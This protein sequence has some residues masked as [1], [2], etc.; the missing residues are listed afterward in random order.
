MLK[1]KIYGAHLKLLH[2]LKRR[3][4]VYISGWE[5]YGTETIV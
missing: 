3:K 2:E 5:I 4:S 1:L